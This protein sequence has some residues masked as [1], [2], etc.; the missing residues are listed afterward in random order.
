MWSIALETNDDFINHGFVQDIGKM[1]IIVT[2]YNSD[3]DIFIFQ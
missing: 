1:Y 2:N 3:G